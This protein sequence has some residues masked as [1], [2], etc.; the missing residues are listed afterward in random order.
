ME[1]ITYFPGGARVNVDLGA[2]VV[3]TDQTVAGGGGGT[4]PTPFQLFLASIGACAG[5]Y[6]L[7]FCRQRGLPTEDV[8]LVQSM[9]VDPATKLVTAVRLDVHL[10]P[11]FPEKYRGALIR[12]AEQCTVRKHFESPPQILV[13]A[14]ADAA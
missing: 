13:H 8:R 9:E 6:I 4:A 14:F 10:P 2:H 12:A 5:T 3:H 7:A 1:Y 11:G